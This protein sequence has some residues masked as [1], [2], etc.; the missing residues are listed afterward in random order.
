MTIHLY[1]GDTWHKFT[2]IAEARK[3]GDDA[4][5]TAREIASDDGLWPEWIE[6]I[7]AF[8]APSDAK[9]PSEFP[10]I[11]KAKPVDMQRPSSAL[12]AEGYDDQGT[13]W[14]DPDACRC[15]YEIRKCR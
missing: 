10:C 1:D 13:Y 9:D 12:D 6:D 14:S 7:Q 4:I 2:T 15:D 8:Q 3:A 5:K 11:L